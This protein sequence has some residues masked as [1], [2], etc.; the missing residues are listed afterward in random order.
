MAGAGTGAGPVA[1]M[2]TGAGTATGEVDGGPVGI[3]FGGRDWRGV[4]L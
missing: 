4:L 1:G 2:S 3:G